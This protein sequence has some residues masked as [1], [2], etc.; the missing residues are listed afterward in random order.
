MRTFADWLRYYKNLDVAPV[1]EALEKMRA[2]HTEK[3][4]DVLK[5]AVSV[6][7]VSLHYLLQGAVER[8]AKLY[9][10]CKEAYEMLKRAVF[11][12]VEGGGGAS[13]LCGTTT[14]VSRR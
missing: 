6:P 5:D 7:G 12:R 3:G 1:L 9:S 14:S 11:F 4:I 13:C 2:F 8:G 10:P